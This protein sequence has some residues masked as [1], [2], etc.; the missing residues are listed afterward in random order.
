MSMLHKIKPLANHLPAP[1]ELLARRIYV[2]RQFK[3]ERE[4]IKG[5]HRNENE[6]PSIIHFSFNKAATQYVKSILKRCAIENGMAPVAIPDYAFNTNFPRLH[7]LTAEE[8]AEYQH[9][10]KPRGYLYSVFAGMIE[11]IPHLEKYKIVLVARDPRDLLVSGYFSI[12][13]SHTVPSKT[14]D[15]YE[16]F[17]K[18]RRK[19]R[20]L[21]VDEYVIAKSDAVRYAFQEYQRLLLEQYPNTYLT[22]YEQMVSDFAG[23]LDRLL[24]Y[25]ELD[26]SESL[27]ES[28]VQ[29]NDNLTPKTENIHKH[30]RKGQ[31]GDYREKLKAETVEYL[32]AKFARILARFGYNTTVRDVR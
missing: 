6:H 29:E 27:F 20:E 19:A 3:T 25:C 14:G 12:T 5:K 4:L 22:T 8:M 7:L 15:K 24:R 16:E 30:L 26:V 11:G 32:D 2:R 18:Q 31:A 23:W 13:Y 10:F 9:I 17:M 28:L 21:T 1:I